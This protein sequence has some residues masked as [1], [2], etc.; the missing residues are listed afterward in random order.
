M[1]ATDDDPPTSGREQAN[2]AHSG[3][4]HWISS[5]VISVAGSLLLVIVV[6]FG[7]VRLWIEFSRRNSFV[8]KR[9]LKLDNSTTAMSV[10]CHNRN[11]LWQLLE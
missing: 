7:S 8:V 4:A 3:H 6:H 11:R 5:P 9:E 1:N 10:S 2:F